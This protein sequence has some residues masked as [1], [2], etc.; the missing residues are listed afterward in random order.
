MSKALKYSLITF[1]VIIALLIIIP[2]F[3]PLN[4]YKGLITSKVKEVTGRDLEINGDIKLSLLP[5]PAITLQGVKLSSIAGAKEPSLLDIKEARA[6][7]SLLPLITG[8]IEIASIE[9]Q[10]PTINLEIL[11]NGQKNW[12]IAKAEKSNNATAKGNEVAV[13]E[14]QTAELP[15]FVKHIKIVNGKLTYTANKEQKI[16]DNINLD[17]KINSIRG[18]IDFTLSG[19][20]LDQ[21][22]VIEGN[23][24]EFEKIIPVTSLINIADEKIKI[25]GK[26]DTDNNSFAGNASI[27]GNSKN[28]GVPVQLQGDYEL[29]TS[30]LADNKEIVIKD[31]KLNFKDIELIASGNY[32]IDQNDIKANIVLNPGNIIVDV[33]SNIDKSAIFNGNIKLQA[34]AIEPLLAA[35]NMKPASPLPIANQKLTFTTNLI[36]NP[37]EITL[38]NINF[39]AANTSLQGMVKLKN[40]QKDII[41]SHN[42]KV[43]NADSFMNLLGVN[44]SNSIGALQISGEVQKIGNVFQVNDK[45]G[46]FGT[47]ILVKGNVN[48]SSNKPNFTLNLQSNLVNLD[49][50]VASNS[51]SQSHARASGQNMT[52]NIPAGGTPWSNDQIDL[53]FLN[54][55]AGNVTASI[56]KLTQGS[57]V[58]DSLRIKLNIENGKLSI[59]SL[60]GNIYGGQLNVAGYV[61]ANKDQNASFNIDLKHANLRNIIPQ[62]GKIKITEGLLSFKADLNTH[63]NSSYKYVS[64]LG[65][66]FSMNALKGKVSGFDLNK[67][68]DAVNNVKN[69]EGILRV[70]NS[71]FAGGETAFNNLVI[72]SNIESGIVKLTECR[73]DASPAIGNATGQINL[74]PYMM[75]VN[76]SVTIGSLPPLGVKLYGSLNNPQHK[77]DL[78]ELQTHLVKNVVNSVVKDLKKGNVKP[79]NIIKNALGIGKKKSA[80]PSDAQ[81]TNNQ[82]NNDNKAS[83]PVNKLLQKGLKKL[84]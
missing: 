60:T 81:P 68:V 34:Q 21:K 25:E 79:E 29:V 83:D 51:A 1:L 16:F 59:N 41:V 9:L 67:I 37:Q 33:T 75:D 50:I 6:A 48:L 62:S 47:D 55:V 4:S 64:N 45:I 13:I 7:L 80:E 76:A 2:F 14:N 10:E 11:D 15:V 12:D 84:F 38:Q 69:A 3:I 57:L 8:N 23:I 42:L 61:Q 28:F 56:N 17:T 72:N 18:P 35:L 5:N 36:Y 27:K 52:K 26:F 40:L 70:I 66:K 32:N 78:K 24:G 74:P 82:E 30:I 54:S 39:I 71:S 46:I 77:L 31:T 73:I 53:S 58:L 65:G 22:I 63:G 43:N 49:K 20:G 44:G 19:N